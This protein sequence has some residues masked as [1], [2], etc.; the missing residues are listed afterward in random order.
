MQLRPRRAQAAAQCAGAARQSA[1]W[2]TSSARQQRQDAG[3][4]GH[5]L[6][7][8]PRP[9]LTLQPRYADPPGPRPLAGA[10]QMARNIAALPEKPVGG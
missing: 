4:Q 3:R 2:L 9:A 6:L 5:A 8:R 1:R 7:G 10:T